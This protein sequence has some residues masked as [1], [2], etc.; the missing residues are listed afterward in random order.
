MTAHSYRASYTPYEH[1]NNTSAFLRFK[2]GVCVNYAHTHDAS[3]GSLRIEVH[4]AN[5]ALILR[6]ER[7]EFS[8]RPSVNF[9]VEPATEVPIPKLDSETGVLADFHDY[10]TNGREP[11]ISARH[12]LETMA[13]CEMMVRS[14]RQQRMVK[15]E[16]LENIST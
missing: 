10:V 12:N 6:D 5:G 13:M 7:A 1:D 16:E 4:G 11:G 14:I 8:A 15:R 9:G 2:N 3:R